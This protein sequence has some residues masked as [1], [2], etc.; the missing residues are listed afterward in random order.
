MHA[1][2]A[3]QFRM[4]GVLAPWLTANMPAI[5]KSRVAAK[6]AADVVAGLPAVQAKAGLTAT[7]TKQV[8]ERRTKQQQAFETRILALLGP[9]QII[10]TAANDM[11]FLGLVTIGR[12]TFKELRPELQ[13]GVGQQVLAKAKANA[14]QL[15]DHAIDAD[16]LDQAQ[17]LADAFQKGLPDT[18]S[19]LDARQNANATYEEVHEAQMAQIYELDK[20][21]SVFEAVN[22]EL[23]QGYKSARAL[24]D[25]A[26]GKAKKG[27]GL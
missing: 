26:G 24:L 23:H 20:A 18:Q 22:P 16:F 5:G 6:E 9:L 27:K 2:R 12:T 10:A 21:M 14:A 8:T 15:E 17:T 19:L 7:E 11:D 25:A 13:A 3:N 4:M 1:F